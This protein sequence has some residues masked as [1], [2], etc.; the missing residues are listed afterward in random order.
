MSGKALNFDKVE[1]NKNKFHGSKK[2][3]VLDSM[4][5]NRIVTPDRFKHS[6]NSFK[7]FIGYAED[8]VI[9]PL[10]IIFPQLRGFMKYF[11]ESGKNMSIMMKNDRVLIRHNEIWNKIKWLIRKKFYSEPVY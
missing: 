4:D 8:D 11:N 5:I 6:D 9:R 7:Y 3:I 2:S 10:C 1:I